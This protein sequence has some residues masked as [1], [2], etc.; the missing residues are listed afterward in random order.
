[1]TPAKTYFI[2]HYTFFCDCWWSHLEL[3]EVTQG[4][5]ALLKTRV[6]RMSFIWKKYLRIHMMSNKVPAILFVIRNLQM[7][8]MIILLFFS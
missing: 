1:M 8:F 7:I 6:E 3:G 2:K 5:D 4:N